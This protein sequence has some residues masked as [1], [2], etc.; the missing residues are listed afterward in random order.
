MWCF[1]KFLLIWSFPHLIPLYKEDQ[2]AG[3]YNEWTIEN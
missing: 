2:G 1:S 3:D